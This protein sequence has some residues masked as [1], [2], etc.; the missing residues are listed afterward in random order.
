M[1][2]PAFKAHIACV[3]I[4]VDGLWKTI[5][6]RPISQQAATAKDNGIVIERLKRKR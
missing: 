4:G 5:N 2:T 3:A 6:G 1:R